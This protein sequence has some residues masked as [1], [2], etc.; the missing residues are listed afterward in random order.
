MPS[1]GA[2]SDP[3]ETLS[4]DPIRLSEIEVRR[5]NQRKSELL[6]IDPAIASGSA[7]ALRTWSRLSIDN[8]NG[9][10]RPSKVLVGLNKKRT[11]LYLLPVVSS[12]SA[13]ALPVAYTRSGFT[14]NLYKVF[15]MLDRF[16]QK[17][18]RDIY[19]CEA[20][21][22]PVMIGDVTG[23]ALDVNLGTSQREPVHEL[24]DEQKSQRKQAAASRKA[25]KAKQPAP[26]EN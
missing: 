16:A 22:A 5:R 4:L 7:L 20:T 18:F 24:S 11:H 3:D 15:A 2:L 6:V 12:D 1:S 14:V 19:K 13:D 26:T 25:S 9:S 8:G 10:N 21:R 17:G 23:R